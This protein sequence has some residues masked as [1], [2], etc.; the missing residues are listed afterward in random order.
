MRRHWI[1]AKCEQP[2][3]RGQPFTRA[4]VPGR[5]PKPGVVSGKVMVHKNERHCEKAQTYRL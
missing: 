2:I 3:L 1:C 4:I 5:L